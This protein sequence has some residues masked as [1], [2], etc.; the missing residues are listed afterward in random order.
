M[1][2]LSLLRQVKLP[3]IRPSMLVGDLINHIGEVISEQMKSDNPNICIDED[4]KRRILDELAHYLLSDSQTSPVSDDKFIMSRVNSL[5]CLFQ[6]EPAGVQP[7]HLKPENPSDQTVNN[8]LNELNPIYDSCE[9]LPAEKLPSLQ[10]G[11]SFGNGVNLGSS[12]SRV[13][14][15]GELLLHLPRIASLPQFLVNVS[16]NPGSHSGE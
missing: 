10:S 14:S 1:Y 5:C 3:G 16:Q 11:A 12:M 8:A 15:V 6:K 13:D 9:S 2:T 7:L 4:Q